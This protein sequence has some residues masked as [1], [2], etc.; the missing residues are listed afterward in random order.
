M[1]LDDQG[2]LRQETIRLTL[3]PQSGQGQKSQTVTS[4]TT[5]R[6]SDFGTEAEIEEPAAGDTVDVTDSSPG[7]RSPRA[8]PDRPSA[9][10][11]SAATSSAIWTAFS[12]APLRRLSLETKRARPLLHRL[13]LADAADVGRVLA[14]GL[15][16]GRDVGDGHARGARQQLRRALGADRA[17]EAGVDLEGVAGEDRDADAGAGDLQLGDLQDLAGLVAELLLLVG[18]VQAVVD[19]RSPRAAAR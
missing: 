8:P 12:A 6:F 9:Q 5:L 13:V 14:G 19:D 2:R 1:W 3:R 10:L 16:G 17:G 7:K 15:E 11:S 18:L 4:T